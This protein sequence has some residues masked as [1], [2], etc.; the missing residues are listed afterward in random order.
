MDLFDDGHSDHGVVISCSVVLICIDL[1]ISHDECVSC[2]FL[3]YTVRVQ[4][5]REICFLSIGPVLNS[6]FDGSPHE[7]T[8]G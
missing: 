7:I 3:S 5:T 8:C 6:V 1:I 2:S 4:F